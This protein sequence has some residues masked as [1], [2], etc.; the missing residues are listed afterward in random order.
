MGLPAR[1]GLLQAAEI[2]ISI[3]FIE[4]HKGC[5]HW[6]KRIERDGGLDDVRRGKRTVTRLIRQSRRQ[7]GGMKPWLGPFGMRVELVDCRKHGDW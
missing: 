6:K 1:L 5:V 3:V 2:K 7:S 4:V